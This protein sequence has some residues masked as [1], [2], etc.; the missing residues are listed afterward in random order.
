MPCADHYSKAH[1]QKYSNI[2]ADAFMRQTNTNL[3]FYLYSYIN[4]TQ[5]VHNSQNQNSKN[6]WIG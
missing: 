3:L 6:Q 5:I 2:Q 1:S 4:V